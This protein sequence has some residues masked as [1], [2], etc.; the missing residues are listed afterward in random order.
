[1]AMIDIEYRHSAEPSAK[2]DLRRG[3]VDEMREY[4]TEL[5]CEM[6]MSDISSKFIDKE[7]EGPNMV[8]I[9]GRTVHQILDGLEIRMVD[10]EESCDFNKK[11]IVSFGRPTLD[12]DR[13][14][15]EDIPDV[16]MKNAIAKIFAEIND[17]RIL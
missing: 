15:I 6:Q 14:V 5:V 1:M 3:S 17:N 4:L 2:G 7:T 13:N 11:T 16:L 12:W 8:Y 9:N 10:A